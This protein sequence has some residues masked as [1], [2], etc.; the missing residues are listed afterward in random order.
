MEE[1]K[2]PFEL[3]RQTPS[4]PK[5]DELLGYDAIRVE[6]VSFHKPYKDR[7]GWFA[8]YCLVTRSNGEKEYQHMAIADIQDDINNGW[9]VFNG[10]T[11]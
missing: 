2:P 9:L 1:I 4:N 11:R 5:E 7:E 10:E 6:D 3:I 8:A